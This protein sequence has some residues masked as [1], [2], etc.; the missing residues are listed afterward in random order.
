M[1]EDFLHYV[2]KFQKLRQ[3]ELFTTQGESVE[4][5]TVGVHNSNAGPDF[6]CA[7]I[8]IAGQLWAGHVEI[9]LA[10]SD[11]YVHHHEQDPIYDAVILHVVWKHDSEIFRTD[12]TK[13]PTLVLR[14]A[15]AP[16][17][18][19]KY[20]HL[21]AK[22]ALWIPCEK[23]FPEVND[24]EL[25]NWLE[26]LFF[27]RLEQKSNY[28]MAQFKQ[29][30]QHWEALLFRLLAK[31]FGLKVNGDSFYYMASRV[32]YAVVKKCSNSLQNLEGLLFGCAGLLNQK[33]DDLYFTDLQTRF[34]FLRK[35]FG[36]SETC[37]MPP[38]YFRLRPANFPTIR[39]AQLARLYATEKNLFSK[40]IDMNTVEDFYKLFDVAASVYWD[41][42]YNFGLASSSRKKRLSK[43]F[44]NL[45]LI[46][47]VIPIKFCYA[48][49]VGAAISEE[50]I[51]LTTAIEA[52]ENSV[53]TK[54]N[55]LQLVAKNAIHSQGLL[56]LK[57]AYCDTRGCLKCAIGNSMLRA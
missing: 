37:D 29:V 44:I 2:W 41:T 45:L 13:I 4:I 23:Q 32:E 42:H 15:V 17:M 50:L 30:G 46:N 18:V 57:K 24:F 9:H 56:Q 48:K 3:A 19:A 22:T 11:W 6:L 31:N 21:F 52:E 8:R 26:R 5:V 7:Q 10:S 54:F 28:I 27:E 33:E 36:I 53:I 55:R 47:T 43:K 25:D 39:I 40:L 16:E 12:N 1:K 20:H 34:D 14:K 38:K 51:T 35:K 49:H